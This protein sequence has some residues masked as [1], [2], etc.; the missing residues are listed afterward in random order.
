MHLR[1]N[2]SIFSRPPSFVCAVGECF[3]VPNSYQSNGLTKHRK[4]NVNLANMTIPQ[5]A[6]ILC[7]DSV[8]IG[9][10]DVSRSSTHELF[11]YI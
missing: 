6:Q 1:I 9:I 11:K 5:I 8:Y 4:K 3:K 10:G 2:E 7:N